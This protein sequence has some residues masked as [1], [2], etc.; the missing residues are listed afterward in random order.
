MMAMSG[1][2][3]ITWAASGG[4]RISFGA[5]SVTL[6]HMSKQFAIPQA[7]AT[8]VRSHEVTSSTDGPIEI[9]QAL[10]PDANASRA[11]VAN[12]KN[13]APYKRAWERPPT[14]VAKRNARERKR[15]NTVNQA[16]LILKYHLP[17]LRSKSKRVSKLKILRAAINYMYA[18]SDIL[19]AHDAFSGEGVGSVSGHAVT[20]PSVYDQT[21]SYGIPP[22][23]YQRH[24]GVT[25]DL[26]AAQCCVANF[27][28]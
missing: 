18:L 21:A 25:Y 3:R 2:R 9:K 20:Y 11:A 24:G 5:K 10:N 27:P 15:V 1:P 4:A 12:A 7:N 6:A 23:A 22:D 28:Y 13:G 16:F 14:S 17:A 19:E 26:A 8:E